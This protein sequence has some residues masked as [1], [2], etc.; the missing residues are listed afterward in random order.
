VISEAQ[1]RQLR[2]AV[3]RR[4]ASSLE[5]V[6]TDGLAFGLTKA[7]P[8]Q[9]AIC[10]VLDG[11]PLGEL[12]S[13]PD[14]VESF[15][16]AAAVAWYEANPHRP[17]EL[18][19]VAGIR[20][21]KSLTAAAMGVRASQICD[22][23][24]LGPG[25]IPRV[26]ILS[27]KLDLAA[28][29]YNHLSGR[30]RE[31]AVL[32]TLLV[33]KPTADSVMLRHPTGR[34]VEIKVVAGSRAGASLVARWSAGVIFDEATRMYGVEDGAVV[35]L[36]DARQAVMGRLLPGAQA[37]YVGSAWAPFG[38][39]FDMVEEFWGKPKRDMIV[40]R[41]KAPAMN[42]TWWT[43]ERCA[44][45]E[46]INPAAHK[47]DVLSLFAD[48]TAS[49]FADD[50]LARA[51]RDL[52][53][54]LPYDAHYTYAAAMDPA[55]SGGNA[56]TLTLATCIEVTF[57]EWTS[58]RGIKQTVPVSK[59]AV[60]LTREWV[61]VQSDTVIEEIA[62]TLAPYHVTSVRTDQWSADALAA[63]G[64]R[65]GLSFHH[66]T[67]TAARKFELYEG[68]RLKFELNEIQLS[69]DPRVRNDLKRVIKKVTQDGYRIELPITPD[70]RHCDFASSTVL[71]L[72][73]PISP[74]R[75]EV[76]HVPGSEAY[77]GAQARDEREK[78]ER[79]TMR[80]NSTRRRR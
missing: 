32:E 41:A 36:D 56:W 2:A 13:D 43:P 6:L 71:A 52:P 30:T 42:P 72:A 46:R 63:I 22:C 35:N 57:R 12:A 47:T 61:G 8:T 59:H 37:I 19:I 70:G 74:P 4:K 69:P 66:E 31:S 9:R 18:C 48:P 29:I 34:L 14:V 25:E 45:L 64:R 5:W 21:A 80:K 75:V 33:G 76:K 20:G 50:H 26:S 39:V 15:G 60:V 27:T 17:R 77:Y 68:L 65:Y 28:V 54:E 16:G 24:M 38:P 51:M 1:L 3:A 10:R 53:E 79:D 73:Y 62:A 67:M 11:Q 23:S 49:M 40:I 55:G 58:D 44:E 78:A 7:T